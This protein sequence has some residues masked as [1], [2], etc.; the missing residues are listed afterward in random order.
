MKKAK[1]EKKPI[2]LYCVA[3]EGG[4]GLET[5]IFLEES[6]A[7]E[8]AKFIGG[9]RFDERTIDRGLLDDLEGK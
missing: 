6:L 4:D 8:W 9:R 1:R 5:D 7:D 3:R 2:L